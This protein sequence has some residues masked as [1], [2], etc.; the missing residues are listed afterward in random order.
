VKTIRIVKAKMEGIKEFRDR[1]PDEVLKEIF[2]KKLNRRKAPEEL[3]THLK[4]MILSG[5][6]KKGQKITYDG[7]ALDFNVSRGIVHK[8]ISQLKKDGLIISKWRK[9]SFVASRS[10]RKFDRKLTPEKDL[11]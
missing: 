2:P 11:K 7:I 3:Y 4:K 10:L 8:V 6:L 9:G 5:K 1:I